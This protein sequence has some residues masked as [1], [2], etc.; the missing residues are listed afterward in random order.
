MI[1]FITNSSFLFFIQP[2]KKVY[3]FPQESRR[4]SIRLPIGTARP[5]SVCGSR[6]TCPHKNATRNTCS[7]TSSPDG[8]HSETARW[9]AALQVAFQVLVSRELFEQ[10]LFA[11]LY[12]PF[13][14][15][16][17]PPLRQPREK[18][19]IFLQ[20]IWKDITCVMHRCQRYIPMKV[21]TSLELIRL[22]S[23]SK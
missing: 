2:C 23:S 18:D 9:C 8:S 13:F 1:G 22:P 10:F 16:C 19:C 11:Q 5:W 12:T 7:N 17:C 20:N 3:S 4:M 15:H 21:K 14:T 6:D